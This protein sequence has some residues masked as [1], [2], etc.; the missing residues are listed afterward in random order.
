MEGI[1][2]FR[3]LRDISAAIVE[4]FEKEDEE[5]L[6]TAMGRFMFLIVQAQNTKW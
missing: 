4:A 1:E 6:E 3:K 2:V 5:A